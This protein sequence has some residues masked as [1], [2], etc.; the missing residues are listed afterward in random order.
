MLSKNKNQL[1][2]LFFRFIQEQGGDAQFT[3]VNEHRQR[4][5]WMNIKH[6]AG[7]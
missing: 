1:P 6:K 7:S 5:Y 4:S 3:N 2:E